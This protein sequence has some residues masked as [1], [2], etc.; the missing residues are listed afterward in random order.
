MY[1]KMLIVN[2]F[3]LHI[4]WEIAKYC[5]RPI[6]HRTESCANE[7]ARILELQAILSTRGGG[8]GEAV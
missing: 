8:V 1:V 4:N 5:T 7:S 2:T 6:Q 3:P